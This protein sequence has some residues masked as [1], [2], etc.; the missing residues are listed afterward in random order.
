MVLVVVKLYGDIRRLPCVDL[1]QQNRDKKG[2]LYIS[3]PV[4]PI[5]IA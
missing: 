4:V 5:G 1:M 2:I 3:L